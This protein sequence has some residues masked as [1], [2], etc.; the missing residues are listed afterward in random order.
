M[1]GA[2]ALALVLAG[3][4]APGLAQQAPSASPVPPAAQTPVLTLDWE[5]L[6]DNSLWGKRVAREIETAS[7][8]LRTENNRIAAQLE[9]E[10]RDLTDRRPKM[11]PAAFQTAADV[12]DKR[13][14]AI[15]AAQKAKADAIQQQ[16]NNERQGFLQA[17]MP[18]LDEVLRA[19]GAEVVLDSRVIIRGLASAD[20]TAQL[21]ERIDSEVGDG[22]GQVTASVPATG[23]QPDSK[24]TAPAAPDAPTGSTNGD[25]GVF[26]DDSLNSNAKTGADPALNG[27]SPPDPTPPLGLPMPKLKN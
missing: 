14:T 5:R 26:V 18:K 3:F 27:G 22:A 8:D 21:G 16:L 7:A 2:F 13:A 24:N 23:T 10:E 9:A 17:V 15:R 6:Y 1:R 19:R 12:F 20:V 4:A 25:G 11:D